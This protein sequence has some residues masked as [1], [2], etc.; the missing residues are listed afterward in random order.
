[1][2]VLCK[3]LAALVFSCLGAFA[4]FATEVPEKPL[5][6]EATI[7]R[8]GDFMRYGFGSVWMMVAQAGAHQSRRQHLH[9]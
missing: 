7:P 9:R 3:L 1:M 5:V 2:K 6:I 8:A 4:A